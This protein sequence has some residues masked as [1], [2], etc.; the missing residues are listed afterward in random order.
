MKETFLPYV[1]IVFPFLIGKH[2]PQAGELYILPWTSFYVM[3]FYSSVITDYLS[4]N[5]ALG[6]ASPDLSASPPRAASSRSSEEIL[7]LSMD[8]FATAMDQ[9]KALPGLR[10]EP[11]NPIFPSLQNVSQESERPNFLEN[12][13]YPLGRDVPSDEALRKIRTANS[14]TISPGKAAETITRRT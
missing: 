11:F 10:H 6:S 7:H 9:E 4:G 12:H 3:D 14:I 8:R 2:L 5:S 13:P 1:C